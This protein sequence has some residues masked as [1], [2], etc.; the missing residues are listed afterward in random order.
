MDLALLDVPDEIRENLGIRNRA[1]EQTQILKVQ[2]TQV[3]FDQGSG[4]RAGDG[5]AT[6]AY[7]EVQKLRKLGAAHDVNHRVNALAP[8]FGQKIGVSRQYARGPKRL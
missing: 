8:E 4:D 2:R 5:V 3:E 6:F 1:S 7:Q